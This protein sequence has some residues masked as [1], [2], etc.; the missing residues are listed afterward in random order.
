MLVCQN[1]EGTR[2]GKDWEPL[3]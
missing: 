3:F 1:A 2:L